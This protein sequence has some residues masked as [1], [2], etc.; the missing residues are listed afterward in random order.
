MHGDFGDA[1]L[2]ATSLEVGL[3]ECLH[4][5]NGLLI[6]DEATRH[7][8]H[9]GIVVHAC[10]ACNLRNPAECRANALVLVERHVDS[11]SAAA[12]SYARIALAAL[13][14][15]GAGVGKVGIVSALGAGG[16]KVA[17]GDSLTLEVLNHC[18]F[19][20]VAGMVA[21]NGYRRVFF[22]Y[23]IFIFGE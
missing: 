12:N 2:V 6:A 18:N 21:A 23:H 1:T 8:K 20:F 14:G 15:K 5:L 9:V 11:L 3:K 4:Y 13:H 7:S 16:A 10:K 17:H 19:G 22:V